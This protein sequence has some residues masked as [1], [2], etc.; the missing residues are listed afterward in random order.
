MK[1]TTKI[2]KEAIEIVTNITLRSALYKL[3]RNTNHLTKD[4][5]VHYEGKLCASGR[6]EFLKKLDKKEDYIKAKDFLE[7]K[8]GTEIVIK[9]QI[10]INNNKNYRSNKAL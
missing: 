1:S 8:P 3:R 5:Y 9:T 7:N 6:V 4:A 10:K 2:K